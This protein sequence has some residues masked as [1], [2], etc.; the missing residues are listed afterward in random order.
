MKQKRPAEV[1]RPLVFLTIVHLIHSAFLPHY[2]AGI[3]MVMM[4]VAM[5]VLVC[6]VCRY[7]LFIQSNEKRFAKNCKPF[8]YRYSQ[9][10]ASGHSAIMMMVVT[11]MRV[12]CEYLFFFFGQI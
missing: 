8:V 6:H 7:L 10:S 11:M 4:V 9:S 5:Y 12:I 3:M 1:R 2:R